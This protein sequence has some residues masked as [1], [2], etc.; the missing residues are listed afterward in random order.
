MRPIYLYLCHQEKYSTAVTKMKLD[1]LVL[2][3]SQVHQV[4]LRYLQ[5][6]TASR[7]CK[8]YIYLSKCIITDCYNPQSVIIDQT[9]L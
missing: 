5:T 6:T 3:V 4:N 2:R 9:F 1:H 8:C 7:H